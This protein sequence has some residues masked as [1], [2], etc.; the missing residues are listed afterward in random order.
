MMV[1]EWD[2]LNEQLDLLAERK[3]DLLDS[4][5]AL[6]GGK[7]SLFAGRKLTMTERA[8]SVQYARVVKDHLPDLDLAPYRGKSSSFWQLR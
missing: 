4:M 5:V 1:A 8:G 3:R 6:A 7:N 2:Q